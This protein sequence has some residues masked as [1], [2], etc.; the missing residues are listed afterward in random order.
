MDT[1]LSLHDYWYILRKRKWTVLGVFL[2]TLF[3]TIVYT[4]MQ[5]PLYRS[6]ATIKYEP[7]ESAAQLVGVNRGFGFDPWG[8]VSNEL[9]VIQGSQVVDLAA[10]ILGWVGRD[11]TQAEI[12]AARGRIGGKLSVRRVESSNIIEMSVTSED[13]VEAA[14]I[15]NAV[16]DAYVRHDT[17]VKSMSARRTLEDITARRAEVEEGLR[18]LERQREDFLRENKTTGGRSHVAGQIRSVEGAIQQM[19]K[20]Y[21][22]EH[23]E[24]QAKLA[25]LGRLRST[26]DAMPS[27]ETE[28]TRIQ[29]DLNVNE[30]VYVTLSQQF[31]KAKISLA[32]VQPYVKP[33]S[34][35]QIPGAPFFPNKRLNYLV[36]GALGM[37]LGFVL[38][39]I[40][41][42]LDISLSTI[43]EIEKITNLPVLGVVPQLAPKKPVDNWLFEIFRKERHPLDL[44]R[45]M[46]LFQHQDKSPAIEVYHTVRANISSQLGKNDKMTIVMSSSG[47]AEGK[48]LTSINFCIAAAH[49]GLKTLLVETDMR[50]P[51]LYRVFG[52]PAEPGLIEILTGRMDWRDVVR[53]TTDFLMGE[54]DLDKLLGFSGIDNLKIITGGAPTKHVVDLF[55]EGKWTPLIEEWERE[56]DIIVFDCPP[57]LLFV[58][59]MLVAPH[60]DGLVM[61]YKA[62]KMARGALRRAKEQIVGNKATVLGVIMNGLRT[63]D[64]EPRYGYYYDY[65]SYMKQQE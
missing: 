42:N 56:F 38:V 15:V 4:Q 64:M 24:V 65:G 39:F 22:R 30:G 45:T 11:S 18:N 43:E 23:P 28:L 44:F 12:A 61:V 31:E 36:G 41:E 14:D 13:P 1:E 25:E 16:V 55:S 48:T 10:K 29:R 40:M 49:A 47:V 60:T 57:V 21:T 20:V 54:I 26:H 7:P 17:D 27:E 9:R 51:S 63:S 52:L 33:V 62:G 6:A 50:K 3:S 59:A 34:R 37:F 19:L 32:S 58:D 8:S 53:S 5:K 46:L 35:G 2:L